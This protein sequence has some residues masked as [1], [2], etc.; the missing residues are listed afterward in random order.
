LRDAAHGLL[1]TITKASTVTA[2]LALERAMSEAISLAWEQAASEAFDSEI[3]ALKGEVSR[4]TVDS[5]TKRM[6]AKL[7]SPLTKKRK[8]IIEKHLKSIWNTA[9][10]V[11]AK[12]MKFVPA[13]GTFDA[14]AVEVLAKHQVFWVDGFYDSHLSERIRAVASD[15]LIERGLGHKEAGEAL[16]RELGLLEGGSTRFAASVPSRYAGNPQ[17]Y[18]EQ[19]IARIQDQRLLLHLRMPHMHY[20]LHQFFYNYYP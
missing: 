14:K 15:V 1:C 4:A 20:I 16:A 7:K 12:E 13:F 9:K 19:V 3:G 11:S 18:F 6:G 10:K 8:A 5:F 2:T 17:L